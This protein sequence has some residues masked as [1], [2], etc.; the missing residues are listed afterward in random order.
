MLKSRHIV[1][2]IRVPCRATDLAG[3][4]LHRPPTP[5]ADTCRLKAVS[6]TTS[7]A[8]WR[9]VTT[10]AARLVTVRSADTDAMSAPPSLAVNELAPTHRSHTSPESL[11]SG[12]LDLAVA[13]RIVHVS[14]SRRTATSRFE[15][16]LAAFGFLRR[17]ECSSPTVFVQ[18]PGTI[19]TTQ[20][21]FKTREPGIRSPCKRAAWHAFSRAAVPIGGVNFE[22]AGAF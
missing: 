20:P 7:D 15:Y 17:G 11:L 2:L 14:S 5:A 10:G 8:A 21:V 12:T 22:A 9:G 1:T 19:P 4:R 6:P 13:S 18:R 3:A 16:A